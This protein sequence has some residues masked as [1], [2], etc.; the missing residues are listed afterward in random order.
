MWGRQ[1][2]VWLQ[3]RRDILANDNTGATFLAAYLRHMGIHRLYLQH[4]EIID[5]QRY[6]VIKKPGKV[7]QTLQ[8]RLHIP[9][10]FVAGKN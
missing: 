10:I 7:F 4:L 5:L 2:K 1:N 8:G 6:K 3:Y 9:F